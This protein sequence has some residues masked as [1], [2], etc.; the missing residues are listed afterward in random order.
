M[1]HDAPDFKEAKMRKS[2]RFFLIMIGVGIIVL[3]GATKEKLVNSTW[4][5]SPLRI[6]G[7][8]DD[9][10]TIALTHEEKVQVDYA[11]MNDAD[12]FYVLF[13]FKDPQ[14]LSS[15]NQTGMTLYFNVDGK[16][17]KDYGINL[18]QKKISA[19]QYITMLEKRDGLLSEADRNN[20]LAHPEYG[21]FDFNVIN[22]KTDQNTPPPP[23]DA[24]P[25][26]YRIYQDRETNTA[27]EMAIP[28]A[29]VAALAPGIG[30]E[31]GRLIK[32]GFEWGGMTE[33]MKQ[34]RMDR[35][36]SRSERSAETVPD[37][38][39]GGTTA[40]TARGRRSPKKYDFWV[41][42]QLAKNQ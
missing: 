16:K 11:F 12:Y 24:K 41:D 19:Q 30:T 27:F 22:K 29:R 18:I 23:D 42:V 39:M 21:I 37:A 13:I 9:W 40:S 26:I 7:T 20:I 15:I 31:P 36:K 17:N 35:F 33:A 34:A 28:L 38:P 2:T 32:V 14:Y 1:K 3:F 25:A 6:D 8:S 5:P 4:C 10:Q